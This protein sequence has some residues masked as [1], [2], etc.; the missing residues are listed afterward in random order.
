[1]LLEAGVRRRRLHRCG[2]CGNG[3]AAREHAFCSF[4]FLTIQKNGEYRTT[5]AASPPT[6]A[7][8]LLQ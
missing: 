5:D 6:S 1:M 7:G 3:R 8:L 4:W 2:S